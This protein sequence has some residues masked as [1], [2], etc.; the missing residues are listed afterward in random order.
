V[1]F[2]N[3]APGWNDQTS[4]NRRS[5]VLVPALLGA[6]SLLTLACGEDESSSGATGTGQLTIEDAWARTSP[7]MVTTGAAYV[8]ITSPV[9]DRLIGATVDPSIA[10]TV[11]LHETM[12]ETVG[13]G[14]SDG[15]AEPTMEMRASGGV[16]LPAGQAVTMAPG[17]YHLMMLDLAAPLERD[18]TFAMTLTFEHADSRDI[19]VTVRDDAP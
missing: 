11:E 14:L 1:P 5:F 16:E 17:G 18:Q 9:D 4:V 10:G 2:G 19:T 7:A 12:T 3:Q 8:T 6:L 15:T 13:T